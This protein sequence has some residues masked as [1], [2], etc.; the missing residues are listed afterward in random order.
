MSNPDNKR[1]RLIL[2]RWAADLRDKDR[3]RFKVT[4]NFEEL[5]NEMWR[6]SIPFEIVHDM[7]S[8]A[9]KE[10]LPSGFVAKKTYAT[11]KHQLQ[12]KNYNEF[13]EDW[14]ES[15]KDKAFQAFYTFYPI[16][17]EG[18]KEEKK[19]GNMSAQEYTKQL[20]Y[21]SSFPTIDIEA[22]KKQREKMMHDIDAN[23][24]DLEEEDGE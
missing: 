2:E 22:L 7:V 15:I 13:L 24:S 6:A 21:A 20:K 17:G 16:D 4:E 3:S 11:L 10:H 9:I 19:Y 18:E 1:A 14:K 8:D 23:F 12:G 5:F